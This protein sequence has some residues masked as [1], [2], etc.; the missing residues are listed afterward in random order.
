MKEELTTKM[1]SEF[2]V[3]PEIE[4]RNRVFSVLTMADYSNKPELWKYAKMYDV[5]MDDIEKNKD[6]FYKLR[7]Q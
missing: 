3:S 2:T 7:N 1:H 5:T 4:I 6:S